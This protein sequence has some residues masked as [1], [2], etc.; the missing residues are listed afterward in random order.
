VHP[1]DVRELVVEQVADLERLVADRPELGVKQIEL[2]GTDVF[3]MVAVE[4]AA[5]AIVPLNIALEIAGDKKLIVPAGPGRESQ[6]LFGIP[7]EVPLLGQKTQREL[8]L[9]IG[10]DGFNGHPP[11]AELLRP[12]DRTLLPDAEWPRD[13]SNQG[14]VEAHPIYKRKFFCR[15]GFREFHVLDQHADHPWD[16]IREQSTIGWLVVTLLGE[17]KTRWKLL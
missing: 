9:R 11:L 1:E 10:C 6:L 12:E 14:I 15:P 3:V 2:E 4:H 13:P 8:L 16:S 7:R 5:S 17:L